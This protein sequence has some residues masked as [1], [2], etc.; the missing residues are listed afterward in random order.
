MKKYNT[1]IKDFGNG[2]KQVKIY[3]FDISVLEDDFEK[4]ARIQQIWDNQV[5]DMRT[6]EEKDNDSFLKRLENN[7]RAKNNVY[8]IARANLWDWFLTL[9]FNPDKVN[10]YDYS[11]C[12][13]KLQKQFN[14]IRSRYCPNMR[15]LLVPEFHKDGGVHFHGLIAN[16]DLV[17]FTPAINPHTGQQI[18]QKG[19]EIYNWNLYTL[20]FCTATSVQDTKRVSNYI[21]KYITKSQIDLMKGKRRFLQVKIANAP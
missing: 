16:C 7:N 19:L 8:D 6:D 17:H 11:E 14:N 20:G 4:M 5:P 2:L 13:K 10:R 3:N 15:Y 1:V 12:L 18:V 9:T 21:T